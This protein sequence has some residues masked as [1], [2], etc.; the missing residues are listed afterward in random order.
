MKPHRLALQD[1]FVDYMKEKGVEFSFNKDVFSAFRA[2]IWVLKLSIEASL[3][4]NRDFA[5]CTE[6]E[7][8]VSSISLIRGTFL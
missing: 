4:N 2:V 1:A 7:D 3:L 5:V 8:I 6:S